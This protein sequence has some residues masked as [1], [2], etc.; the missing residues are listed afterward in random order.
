MIIDTIEAVQQLPIEAC[1]DDMGLILLTINSEFL[2]KSYSRSNLLYE[3]D[4]KSVGSWLRKIVSPKRTGKE[5]PEEIATIEYF[6][7]GMRKTSLMKSTKI[8]KVANS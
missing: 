2:A 6:V 5:P 3:L 8:L 7:M 4:S 1:V